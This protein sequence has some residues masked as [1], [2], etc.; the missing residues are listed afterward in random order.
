MLPRLFHNEQAHGICIVLRNPYI[1]AKVIPEENSELRGISLPSQGHHQQSLPCDSIFLLC[2]PEFSYLFEPR[3]S[4]ANLDDFSGIKLE[5]VITQ[6]QHPSPTSFLGINRDVP[7]IG[8]LNLSYA[9]STKGKTIPAQIF[10]WDEMN[11]AHIHL[12]F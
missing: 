10:N 11:F 7:R 2:E 8:D 6:F 5:D 9:Q 12:C 1:S 4:L 3:N